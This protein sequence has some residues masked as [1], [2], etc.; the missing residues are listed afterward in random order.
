M[1]QEGSMAA[2]DKDSTSARSVKASADAATIPHDNQVADRGPVD[3]VTPQDGVVDVAKVATAEPT[4]ADLAA[5]RA[6]RDDPDVM[7]NPVSETGVDPQHPERHPIPE[8]T[9]GQSRDPFND[10]TDAP[11]ARAHALAKHMDATVRTSGREHVEAA[12]GVAAGWHAEREAQREEQEKAVAAQQRAANKE[13]DQSSAP[14]G[15]T[16]SGPKSRT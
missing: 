14:E 4:R 5:I 7:N 10:P 16:P 3:Q 6:L 2:S 13:Q 15:R 12:L 11:E 1:A 8:K 9:P